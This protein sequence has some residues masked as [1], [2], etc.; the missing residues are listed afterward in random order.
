MR[1]GDSCQSPSEPTSFL[2]LA[3]APWAVFLAPS[4]PSSGFLF[5]PAKQ[6]ARGDNFLKTFPLSER[7]G[8]G[9]AGFIPSHRR[10]APGPP[11]RS[12]YSPPGRLPRAPRVPR[13]VLQRTRRWTWRSLVH[14][15]R[16]A[17]RA[18]GVGLP[19]H[20]PSGGR[21]A[22]GCSPRG[23]GRTPGRGLRGAAAGPGRAGC[24]LRSG[25][26]G[27]EAGARSSLGRGRA[28]AGPPGR[29]VGSSLAPT[30]S[31]RGWFRPE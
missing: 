24:P 15:C 28:P 14:W 22:S 9:G 13:T 8:G 18:R 2:S 10:A 7:P 6:W 12:T 29:R 26:K 17:P 27:R 4:L 5:P 3:L 30:C 1:R 20:G 19:F 23:R 31:G 25:R 11:N 21:G 16:M